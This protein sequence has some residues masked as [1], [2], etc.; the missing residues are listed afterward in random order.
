MIHGRGSPSIRRASIASTAPRSSPAA[1]RN[2]SASSAGAMQPAT[3]SACVIDSRSGCI[4][5]VWRA[6]R[7]A[8]RSA[9][10]PDGL[11]QFR[12]GGGLLRRHPRQGRRGHG[13][14]D[15]PPRQ[16][17]RDRG[18]ALEVGVGTGA[19][20]LPLAARGVPL[21]GIDVSTAMMTKLVEKAGGRRPFPLLRA[22]A[23]RVPIRDGALAGAYARHVLHLISDWRAVVAELCRVV[24]RG[25]VL[26]D[27]GSGEEAGSSSGR[28][29]S[30]T[31][32]RGGARRPRRGRRRRIDVLDEAFAASGGRAPTVEEIP[33]RDDLDGRRRVSPS[34]RARA[35]RGPGASPTATSNG[36]SS[37]HRL[38]EGQFGTL[39]VRLVE[40]TTVRWRIYDVG[41]LNLPIRSARPA[42]VPASGRFAEASDA[43]SA[44]AARARSCCPQTRPRPWHASHPFRSLLP[45]P[46][47]RAPARRGKRMRS[48]VDPPAREGRRR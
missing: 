24:G 36:R 47:L 42:V 28:R 12:S 1:R 20:A 7:R 32:S 27:V 2:A 8:V 38:D 3:A 34:I 17:F 29:C 48:A 5:P 14:D 18:P 31:W 6:A 30:C 25:V 45:Y 13:A 35:R 15:R 19:I 33:S 44:T 22:D 11:G 21:V 9:G 43:P 41:R 4:A 23:T 46:H 26:I 10:E 16:E 39:D 40:E 37:W